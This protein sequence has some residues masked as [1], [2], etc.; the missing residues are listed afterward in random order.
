MQ[1]PADQT[2]R[3]RPGCFGFRASKPSAPLA[4]R[5]STCSVFDDDPPGWPDWAP[6]TAANTSPRT[7]RHS[8]AIFSSS[9]SG[10]GSSGRPAQVE[11]GASFGPVLKALGLA[12]GQRLAPLV[13][14]G[15]S[16]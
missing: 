11:V 3:S 6:S 14:E 4:S 5:V 13:P 10:S 2:T 12:G 7:T 9:I 8:F 15:Y 16:G 1:C